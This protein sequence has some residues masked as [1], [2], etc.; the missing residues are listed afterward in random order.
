MPAPVVVALAI[1]LRS[2]GGITNGEA[3]PAIE[4]FRTDHERDV[5]AQIEVRHVLLPFAKMA[6]ANGATGAVR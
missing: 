1:P 4:R 6:G 5:S 3:T 2:S